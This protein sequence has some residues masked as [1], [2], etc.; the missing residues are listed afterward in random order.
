MGF[1]SRSKGKDG[2]TNAKSKKGVQDIANP[3]I[4]HL[5]IPSIQSFIG[6]GTMTIYV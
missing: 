2:A 6:M 4:P 3:D 5:A 1:F